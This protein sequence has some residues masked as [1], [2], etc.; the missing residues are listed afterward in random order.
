MMTSDYLKARTDSWDLT[1]GTHTPR[2]GRESTSKVLQVSAEWLVTY[3][4]IADH[5]EVS[6]AF[7]WILPKLGIRI[8]KWVPKPHLHWK[9]EDYYVDIVYAEKRESVWLSMDL[10][11][12]FL[13]YDNDRADLIDVD[14]YVD[15]VARG[16]IGQ[17]LAIH[18]LQSATRFASR[19]A[20]VEF[21]T[22]AL[23]EEEGAPLAPRPSRL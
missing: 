10:Y 4:A 9:R 23:L 2:S 8:S 3:D 14:E 13:V 6:G 7:R 20:S 21:R 5:D 1:A 22:S 16:L 18:A 19:L 17:E 12:D 11:L 15:A